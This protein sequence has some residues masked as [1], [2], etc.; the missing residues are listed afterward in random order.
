MFYGIDLAAHAHHLAC[1]VMQPLPSA[2]VPLHRRRRAEAPHQSNMLRT[3]VSSYLNT[4]GWQVTYPSLT[5][6][7]REKSQ[8]FYT[9]SW[10]KALTQ[11]G[12][13]SIKRRCYGRRKSRIL[14]CS[15]T[16]V[17]L[18]SKYFFFIISVVTST[19]AVC[20]P[21]DDTAANCETSDC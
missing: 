13:V 14:R 11:A 1:Y 19:L 17:M 12:R 4:I 9:L 7:F 5:A 16:S 8:S 20:D 3:P 15:S 2:M 21:P 6:P 10:R 18:A